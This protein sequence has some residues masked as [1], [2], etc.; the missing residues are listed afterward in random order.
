MKKGLLYIFTAGAVLMV[1]LAL[2]PDRTFD[3]SKASYIDLTHSFHPDIPHGPGLRAEKIETLFHY[4]PGIGTVGSGA[5]IYYYQLPGQWGTHVD[6][7]AHFI[8]G[9]RYLDD[10]PVSEMMLPLVVLDIH[11]QVRTDPDY[12][13]SL[14]DVISWE[15]RNGPIPEK[16]FVAL[17]SDWSKRWPDPTKFYNRD[18]NDIAHTPG[19]SRPVLEYLITTR[20]ITAIGHETSDT[21]PGTAASRLD[22]TLEIYFLSHD[23]Y[24]IEMMTNLDKLPEAGAMIVASWPKAYQGSGFPARVFAIITGGS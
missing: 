15:S 1:A 17:R 12:Q 6:A 23:K 18:E 24:Q 11:E 21:D 22:F 16:S 14:E 4:D 5:L 2:T 13:V 9:K 20:N 7:P 19:W 8:K 10:I 3:F